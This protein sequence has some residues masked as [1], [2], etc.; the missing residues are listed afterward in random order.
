MRDSVEEIV[1]LL[2]PYAPLVKAMP[3]VGQGAGRSSKGLSQK[4]QAQ[5]IRV[6]VHILILGTFIH[7]F[8]FF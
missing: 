4:E 2:A 6:S 7:N 3:F 1:K 5:V 8:L